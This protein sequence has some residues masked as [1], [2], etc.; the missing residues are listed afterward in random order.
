M[1]GGCWFLDLTLNS[2]T[3]LLDVREFGRMK[4]YAEVTIDGKPTKYKTPVD[5]AGETN[6]TWNLRAFYNLDY[7]AVKRDDTFL[8][9]KLYCER[10]FA[11]DKYVGELKMSIKW[12]FDKRNGDQLTVANYYVNRAKEDGEF[13]I[14]NFSYRLYET[15]PEMS[16]ADGDSSGR[17][18]SFSR[19]VLKT[20]A[21]IALESLIPGSSDIFF[22]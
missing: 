21:A 18:E 5:Y 12:L 9:I 17:K 15:S 22:E 3:G 1:A 6:P 10:S 8:V 13:G 7:E 16:N 4:V 11:A 19:T 2:A 20:A 14:L